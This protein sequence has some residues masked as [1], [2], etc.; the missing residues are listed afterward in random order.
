MKA[1]DPKTGGHIEVSFPEGPDV[2]LWDMVCRACGTSA[3]GCF[4]GPGLPEPRISRYAICPA[5]DGKDIE[6]VRVPTSEGP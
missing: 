5:C 3:G 6:L 2:V 1:F 4:S